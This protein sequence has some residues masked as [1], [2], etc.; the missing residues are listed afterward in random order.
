MSIGKVVGLH[1]SKGGVPKL[2]TGLLEVTTNGC[3]G[4]QQN[5]LKHH[6]GINKA[7]CIFQE[8]IIDELVNNGHPISPGSTGENILITGIPVGDIRPGVRLIFPNVELVITQD[9]PPCKTIKQSFTG[10][11]FKAISHKK[12]PYFTRWYAKVSKEGSVRV[13]DSIELFN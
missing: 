4:D 2:T 8:E 10:G 6:G 11:Q 7:V 3:T 5:D 1:T 9:A 13:G 12:R